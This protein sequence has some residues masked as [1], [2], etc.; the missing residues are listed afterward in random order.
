VNDE[1]KMKLDGAKKKDD[2]ADA[3]LQGIFAAR[4]ELTPRPVKRKREKREKVNHHQLTA[5]AA[6]LDL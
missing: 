6:V 4:K 3:L 2:L 5:D 1:W